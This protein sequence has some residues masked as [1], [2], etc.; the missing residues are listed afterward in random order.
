[1]K[2]FFKK[3]AYKL[4]VFM[5]G[6]YGGDELSLFLLFVFLAFSVLSIIPYCW[7]L[8]PLGLAASV[9]SLFRCFSKNIYKRQAER[10]WFLN[11]T[12]KIKS[13]FRRRK[14]I[15]KERKTHKF[16]KCKKCGAVLRVPKGKGKIEITCPKCKTKT[17]KKT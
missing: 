1:M 13:F 7:V 16:F 14:R 17:T 10:R 5:Y 3:A 4:S 15:F 12:G 9:Y 2:D 8:Y 6:R 11:L